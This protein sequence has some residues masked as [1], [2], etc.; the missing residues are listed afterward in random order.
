MYNCFKKVVF[1][2]YPDLC[3]FTSYNY[4]ANSYRANNVLITAV[5]IAN[6]TF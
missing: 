2:A 5:S 4:V 1:V 3:V 6:K